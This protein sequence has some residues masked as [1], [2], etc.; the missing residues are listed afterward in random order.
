MAA[1]LGYGALAYRYFEK[2]VLDWA[3]VYCNKTFAVKSTRTQPQQ[4]KWL[5][6]PETGS[7]SVGKAPKLNTYFI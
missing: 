4:V 2:P 6:V 3:T 7:T 5:T 1:V